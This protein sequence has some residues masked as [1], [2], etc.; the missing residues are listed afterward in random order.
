MAKKD[1]G[2]DNTL[3]EIRD[4]LDRSIAANTA[5][6]FTK[7]Q[8]L[9]ALPNMAE[10]QLEKLLKVLQKEV[11]RNEEI[12][13]SIIKEDPEFT[14]KIKNKTAEIKKNALEAAEEKE[15][16]KKEHEEILKEL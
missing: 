3:N 4:L 6:G 7:Q 12:L 1:K 5:E 16:E 15:R 2:G 11:K 13:T 14:T 8:V 9:D 10:E